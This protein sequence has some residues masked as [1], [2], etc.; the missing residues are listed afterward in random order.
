MQ[1]L[2]KAGISSIKLTKR[3]SG[4]LDSAAELVALLGKH[5]SPSMAAEAGK[6]VAAIGKI[7]YELDPAATDGEVPY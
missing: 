2:A 4:L 3:E 7:Q 6:A 5:G 1:V